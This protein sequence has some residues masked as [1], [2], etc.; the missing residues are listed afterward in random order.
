MNGCRKT[1]SEKLNEVLEEHRMLI[2]L[3]Q[4]RMDNLPGMVYQCRNDPP[5]YTCTYA[6]KG[7]LALIGYTPEELIGNSDFKY[8]DIVHPDDVAAFEKKCSETLSVGL[9]LEH[10]YRIITKDGTVKWVMERS[11][12][13]AFNP[14][15]TPHLIEGLYTDITEQKRLEAI[16]IE[17][18]ARSK[19]FERVLAML[20]A[21]PICCQLWSSNLQTITCNQAGVDLYG[22]E[23]KAE[24]AERFIDECS[25]EYQPDGQ[26]SDEKAMMLIQKAIKDGR[27]DFDWM[28][29]IPDT[30]DLIP[31]KVSL[32]RVDSKDGFTVVGVTRDMREHER[33]MKQ[34]DQ[35]GKHLM[36]LNEVSSIL[37][38]PDD[39]NFEK[40]LLHAMKLL[41][42]N[43]NVHRVYVW[44][45]HTID[46]ELH[47]SQLYEWSCGAV[48]QQ[49]SEFSINVPYSVIPT[50][51][52]ALSQGECVNKLV[53]D[54]S[55]TEKP[56]FAAQGIK[57]MLT[58]P[59][60]LRDDSRWE[61]KGEESNDRRF[62]GFVGFDDCIAERRFT[63]HEETIL[64]SAGKLIANALIRN[65]KNQKIRSTTARLASVINN[66]PGFIC[67]VN[68]DGNV[69]L[70]GGTFF[71]NRAISPSQ[72]IG[73]NLNDAKKDQ[74]HEEIKECIHKTFAE[75]GQDYTVRSNDSTYHLYTTAIDDGSGVATEVVISA[76]D[77][78]ELVDAKEA[79]ERAN[80]AKS[81]F[82][83]KMSHEIRTPMNAIIGMTELALREKEVS[84][85]KK[86]VATSRQASS[87]LLSI[88]NDILDFSKIESGNLEIEPS[89]YSVASLINDV[90]NI[91]RVKLVDS[92]VKFVVNIDRSIPHTLYGDE[93]KIRQVLINVLGN[94]VKYTDEGFVSLTM[95]GEFIEPVEPVHVEQV[96]RRPPGG[97]VRYSAQKTEHASRSAIADDAA[98]RSATYH[99]Q[100][101]AARRS[102][103]HH[104]QEEFVNDGTMHLVI[105][106]EDSGR[107]IRQ[108]DIDKL[109]DEF[110][111]LDKE[112]N[113]E[114]EGIGLG[115]AITHGIVKATGGTIDVKS[116]YGKGSLFTIVLPQKYH[117]R[118]ALAVVQNPEKKSV[119]LY[120][121]RE[122]PACSI[123]DTFE[124]LGVQC[125]CVLDD[126]EL[127]EQMESG[128]Y[129]FLLIPLFL[130]HRNKEKILQFSSKT[131]IV[132]LAEFDETM[133]DD[134]MVSLVTPI[135]SVPAANV[136]NG[137]HVES[138]L[139]KGYDRTIKF[140]APT[141]K[142]LIVDDM[143]MNLRVARGL[144]APYN[145]QIELCGSGMAAIE[146]VR[147]KD[148]DLI[149]MDHK[150]PG[151]DGFETVK[152]IRKMGY[153]DPYYT[154]VPIVALTANAVVGVRQM[155]FDNGFNDFLSKPLDTVK[156]H[157]VLEKWIPKSKRE[158]ITA[159]EDQ[160]DAATMSTIVIRGT[161]AD[162]NSNAESLGAETR[163]NMEK[164]RY[165][166]N[167]YNETETWRASGI[168]GLNIAKWCEQRGGDEETYMKLLRSY[169]NFLR[170]TLDSVE[171]VSEDN[172]S[173]YELT[174][175]SIK[176]TSLDIGVEQIGGDAGRLEKAAESR[177]FDYIKKHN[178]AF[179]EAVRKLSHDLDEMFTAIKIESNKPEK[180]KPDDDMLARLLAAS[181]A[182]D[183]DGV[184]DA[185]AEIDKY[186]Y[187]SDDGLVEWLQEWVELMECDPIIEK[188][189]EYF[190]N[191][192]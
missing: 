189:T 89:D 156:L 25:P 94:A 181:E 170:S 9:R 23:S 130:Y 103:T 82:L 146:A 79:A 104:K 144:M 99:E 160:F 102:A 117:T 74:M 176:G 137:H 72:I 35:R 184:E 171:S 123:V 16:E 162:A 12:V 91:I 20:D 2:Q 19:E 68:R 132:M 64:Y 70:A 188:L 116:E 180:D 126:D 101:V 37:L 48:P 187:A 39:E 134:D 168:A 18:Q 114:I 125:T 6:N 118:E 131:K 167:N 145:M 143:Y 98:R 178:P 53:R 24:Y 54:L 60:F 108:D 183:M 65:E 44:K 87:N 185:M 133:P 28:H 90:I 77:I 52:E 75:G 71:N 62:W 56:H 157:E 122:I 43:A 57:S 141:A 139:D 95:R 92:T 112:V 5:N 67:S 119:L 107:G 163:E 45:N 47:C 66:H 1:A 7:S 21:I 152:H 100:D 81:D 165:N 8:I 38:E 22:F 174:V 34:I 173:S 88:I 86:Y 124:N 27:C 85:V 40:N 46:G 3:A 129:A 110:S 58:M 192:K 142:V 13:I 158:Q 69:G 164:S 169:S 135:Y 177:D 182:Y 63:Q 136:L 50:W 84:A 172:L 49:G 106:I 15:G 128:A 14:D 41:A 55:P 78:S 115:L 161:G 113:K 73:M 154:D 80:H 111:Q 59:I 83:A 138:S 159:D 17:N 153:H 150:M 76:S 105:D 190:D 191:K 33:M 175:H 147:S 127:C 93:V 155:F 51:F 120:E 96:G 140:S 149:F 186:H 151:M 61:S 179:F 31:A 166:K 4:D 11:R 26:R 121:Q 29:Q 10:P 32:I 36:T 42:H 97:D 30:Y 109:F 148:Y